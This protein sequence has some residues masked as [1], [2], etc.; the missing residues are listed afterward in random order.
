[1]TAFS[2]T[3]LRS[4]R[5]FSPQRGSPTR[6]APS[7]QSDSQL[8]VLVTASRTMRPPRRAGQVMFC[9]STAF[10]ARDSLPNLLMPSPTMPTLAPPADRA[11]TARRLSC[12]R[13]WLR[14]S[15]MPTWCA[16]RVGRVAVVSCE[17]HRSDAQP[18]QLRDGVSALASDCIGDREA[19][20]SRS[21]AHQ[22]HGR[23]LLLE[24]IQLVFKV[25][26]S[27]TR[28]LQ[29]AMVAQPVAHASDDAFD[30]SPLQRDLRCTFPSADACTSRQAVPSPT[31]AVCGAMA[32]G[33]STAPLARS[34]NRSSIISAMA[35]EHHHHRR[36]RS[37]AGWRRRSPPAHS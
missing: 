14:T 17:H 22:H 37:L 13:S 25:R 12:G 6:Q 36:F 11:S 9:H 4:R 34:S 28:L 33:P 32:I 1:M 16:N 19:P 2:T 31:V 8:G 10:V 18:L 3:R 26:R 35:E 23:A 21:V 5:L 29:E 24:R 15:S 30:P 20:D 7:L 27:G